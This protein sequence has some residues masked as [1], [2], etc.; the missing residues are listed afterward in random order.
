MLTHRIFLQWL[1][2]VTIAIFLAGA[3]FF[4]GLPQTAIA[5]DH[6]YMSIVL[7]AIY[8]IGECVI[9]RQIYLVSHLHT[10]SQMLLTWLKANPIKAIVDDGSPFTGFKS[11]ASSLMLKRSPIT[12]HITAIMPKAR[13]GQTVDQTLLLEGFTEGLYRRAGMS[14]FIS[15]RIVWVGILATI[16]GV[17]IAFWPFLAAGSNL[18]TLKGNMGGFFSGVAVAFIPTALSFVFK[19]AL[20]IGD[21][22]VETGICEIV[23]TTTI[24]SESYVIPFLEASAQQSVILGLEVTHAPS[25]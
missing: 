17:I 9:A 3:A 5:H 1:L 6:S 21:H 10:Q 2:Y 8:L 20:D 13:Y 25:P 11:A 12:D 16:V 19:I 23:E 18:D 4:V 24:A 14:S 22:I 15:S 7:I